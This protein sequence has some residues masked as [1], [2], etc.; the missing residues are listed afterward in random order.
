MRDGGPSITTYCGCRAKGN[1][2]DLFGDGC[3]GLISP[4][5]TGDTARRGCRFYRAGGL[6]VEV[7]PVVTHQVIQYV[8]YNSFCYKVAGTKVSL[9]VPRHCLH[10]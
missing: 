9:T 7:V 8:A 2:P 1:L 4:T 3:R 10:W 5:E 6:I